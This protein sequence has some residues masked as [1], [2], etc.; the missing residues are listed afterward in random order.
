MV[1]ILRQ[2]PSRIIDELA[3]GCRTVALSPDGTK[4]AYSGDLVR[5][6]IADAATGKTI[7]VLS[8]QTV[9]I[10]LEFTPDSKNLAVIGRD[11]FLRLWSAAPVA[12]S[13]ADADIWK[14]RVQRGQKA[15]VSVSPDGKLIAASSSA[16][17]KVVNAA[18]GSEVFTVGNLFEFGLF[19]HS[20]FS[21]DSRLIIAGTDG[22]AGS[23][24][25]WEVATRTL[26]HRYST[27]FGSIT[28]LGIF[29]DGTKALS[30]GAEETV[31]LWDLTGRHGKEAPK[32]AEL[33]TAWAVLDSLEGATGVPAAR[34][35]MA[36]G[37]KS[38][39][40][41][42]T[43]LEETFG[44]HK[45]LV[46]WAKDLASD[47]FDD[48]EAATK[49]L[50][51]AGFRALPFVQAAAANIES[52]EA[53]KR[54]AEIITYLTAKGFVVPPHGLAGDTLRLFRSVQVLEALGGAEAKS[55]LTRIADVAGAPGDE[56]KAALKR[57]GK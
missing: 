47:E 49:A 35:L 55:L 27:G 18:D 25:V 53:K 12:E 51:E 41:I 36:G 19:H 43:G 39:P 1:L 14:T 20:A 54:A 22:T 4:V 5:I 31:T 21:P 40:T 13:K 42:T 50:R 17:L 15:T 2:A 30:A 57:M 44:A 29:P 38:L 32:P 16:M 9:G 10:A 33:L 48:R 46:K 8:T 3:A 37:S 56:A 28:R 26:V 7:R 34:T 6:A 23:V 52:P 11:G 45:N 24:L